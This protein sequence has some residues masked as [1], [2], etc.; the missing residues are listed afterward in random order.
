MRCC[1]IKGF[2]RK[3]PLNDDEKFEGI[4][5]MQIYKDPEY[6]L[7]SIA[8]NEN[9]KELIFGS[10]KCSQFEMN[11]MVVI[12]HKFGGKYLCLEKGGKN[13]NKWELTGNGN[14]L[15]ITH[16]SGKWRV[17]Y[18]EKSGIRLRS[19]KTGKCLRTSRNGTAVDCE[20]ISSFKL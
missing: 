1:N 10:R 19:R 16:K 14:E 7:Y 4:D 12:K 3:K 13:R 6:A 9:T 2:K 8:L 20:G 11:Q 15:K 17:E 5:T 18:L